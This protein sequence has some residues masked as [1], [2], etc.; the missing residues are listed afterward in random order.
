M[1]FDQT[2]R[3]STR[4]VHLVWRSLVGVRGLGGLGVRGLQA[5]SGGGGG[6]FSCMPLN[7]IPGSDVD[8]DSRSVVETVVS[9]KLDELWTKSNSLVETDP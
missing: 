3:I 8:E 2:R 4:F 9:S 1:K 6:E 7:M 5:G